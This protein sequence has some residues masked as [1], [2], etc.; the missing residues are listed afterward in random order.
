MQEACQS[1]AFGD[2][3]NVPGLLL[4]LVDHVVAILDAQ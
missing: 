4:A 3:A 1:G 2:F